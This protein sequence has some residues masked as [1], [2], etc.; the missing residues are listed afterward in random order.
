MLLII[1]SSCVSHS[2]KISNNCLSR[3][4]FRQKF[5]RKIWFTR[6]KKIFLDAL[7]VD[8]TGCRGLFGYEVSKQISSA[9]IEKLILI[10]ENEIYFAT[11]DSL[12]NQSL[13]DEF[14]TKNSIFTDEDKERIS[15]GFHV[16]IYSRG[17]R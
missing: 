6:S 10:G 1:V 16:E 13:L 14:F 2:I 9:G 5:G 15:A 8:G 17:F 12:K 3:T 7:T 4:E 11:S